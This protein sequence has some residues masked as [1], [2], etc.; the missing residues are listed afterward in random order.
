[1]YQ[2]RSLHPRSAP[3][4]QHSTST[5]KTTTLLD[6]PGINPPN[7][8]SKPIQALLS[9]PPSV[10][11]TAAQ[12]VTIDAF[13]AAIASSSTSHQPLLNTLRTQPLTEPKYI[14]TSLHTYC[15]ADRKLHR[16]TLPGFSAQ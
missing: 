15:G 10:D 8:F 1:M 6:L 11:E 7:P 5:S 12:L 14:P 16:Q 13:F 9:N 2:D 3:S 4:F